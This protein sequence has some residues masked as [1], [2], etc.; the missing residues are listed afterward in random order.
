MRTSIEQSEI[1]AFTEE[2]KK[3]SAVHDGFCKGDISEEDFLNRL[4]RFESHELSKENLFNQLNAYF[5][6]GCAYN[7]LKIRNLDC[8]KAY[9][10]NEYKDKEVCFFRNVLYIA[11]HVRKEE[12][13]S[14][15]YSA[16]KISMR[17]T[18]YLA[19][20]YDHLGRFNEALQYYD[21]AILDEANEYEVELN[22]GFCYA[23][24]HAFWSETE[25]F[26]VRRAQEI[27]QKYPRKFD[28][29]QPG[30]REMVCSWVVPSF[31]DPLQ[32]F[33]DT[34]D[35]C[36]YRWLS[37]NHLWLNRYSDVSC[38]SVLAQGHNLKLP[39]LHES[40]ERH[41]LF[42]S[43]F[44]E[45]KEQYI[46]AVNGLYKAIFS[47]D[48]VNEYQLKCSF[49]QLYSILDK[50]ALFIAQYLYIDLP[51][52]SINFDKVWYDKSRKNINP[53][54]LAY[55]SNLSLH[56]IFSIHRDVYANDA[57]A[58]VPDEQSKDLRKIRNYLEHRFIKIEDGPMRFDEKQLRISK[59]E[60]IMN[61]L[62]IAQIVRCSLI[63]LCNFLMHA[64][65]DKTQV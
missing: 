25:P 43:S 17:A 13:L 31:E 30:L 4:A 3:F 50:T 40:K 9:Y 53:K 51:T 32:K 65:Y 58:Y 24:M 42:V 23:N 36:Y 49:K 27:L 20:A 35:G 47:D 60:L 19:N 28:R 37:D 33:E 46:E 14:L 12:W 10:R 26:V 61:A 63:Y 22:K 16:W 57:S 38:R 59:D 44:A 5:C 34:P 6:L 56:A 2:I 21:E 15:Y 41:E 1:T 48:C 62:K 39:C 18:L 52:Q 7:I 8:S 55:D 45:M 64:E 54:I 11:N 29:L